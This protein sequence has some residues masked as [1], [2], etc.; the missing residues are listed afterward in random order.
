M[1]PRRT[2][3]QFRSRDGRLFM[4]FVFLARHSG[5]A[6]SVTVEQTEDG[7]DALAVSRAVNMLLRQKA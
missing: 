4:S 6:F 7:S 2:A 5:R 1:I 3:R